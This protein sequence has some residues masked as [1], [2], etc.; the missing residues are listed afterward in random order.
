MASRT[1]LAPALALLVLLGQVRDITTGQPLPNVTVNIGA[2][3]ATTDAQGRYRIAGVKP[4]Q[5]TLSASSDDVPLQHRSVVVQNSD[6][7]FN[8]SL[9][10]TTLDYSCGGG[11][12]GPG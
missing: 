4:G 5:Y 3:H 8:F 11:A 2:H 6:T 9:C 7:T 1:L 12:D 10:S